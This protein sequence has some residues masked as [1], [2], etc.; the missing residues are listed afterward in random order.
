MRCL[1]GATWPSTEAEPSSL[2]YEE[3]IT[4]W[5]AASIDE[6]IALA[7]AEAEVYADAIEGAHD[8]YLG[9]A[10]AYAIGDE[11]GHGTEVFSLMRS[12]DL[13]RT[14][15]IDTFFDTGREHQR[16]E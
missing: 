6:G 12:S 13:D 8:A 5:R 4:L 2:R 14:T 1:F 16:S 15:Y 7:E 10:Q 9:L 11:P 3:R